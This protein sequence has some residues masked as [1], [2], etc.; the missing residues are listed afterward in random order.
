MINW[1]QKKN[2]IKYTF[3]R[4]T[5]HISQ[6]LCTCHFL[7]AC[8]SFM[9]IRNVKVRRVECISILVP[10]ELVKVLGQMILLSLIVYTVNVCAWVRAVFYEEYMSNAIIVFLNFFQRIFYYSLEVD[11][12]MF[13]FPCIDQNEVSSAPDIPKHIQITWWHLFCISVDGKICRFLIEVFYFYLRYFIIYCQK[14]FL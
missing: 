4:K 11:I 8:F 5:E 1:S 2:G 10:I 14:T 6:M 9:D 3:N 7:W 13:L 12:M